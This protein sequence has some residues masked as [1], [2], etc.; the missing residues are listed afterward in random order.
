MRNPTA[1]V[2]DLALCVLTGTG[3]AQVA[4]GADALEGGPQPL[5]A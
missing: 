1:L 3:G 4:G 2:A 5:A